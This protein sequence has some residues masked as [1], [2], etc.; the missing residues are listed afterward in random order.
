ML[1]ESGVADA[2]GLIHLTAWG[3]ADDS[4]GQKA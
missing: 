4:H 1:Y 3:D 2:D